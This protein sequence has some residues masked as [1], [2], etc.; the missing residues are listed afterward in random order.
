MER[1]RPL[2][3]HVVVQRDAT[4]VKTAGGVLLADEAQRK[5]LYG[6]VVAVGPGKHTEDGKRRL[7][8]SVRVGDRVLFSRYRGTDLTPSLA[9]VKRDELVLVVLKE[10]DIY[11]VLA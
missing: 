6:T 9:E 4:E 1:L 8:M 5:S 7:P 2:D 11:A 10:E 3:D